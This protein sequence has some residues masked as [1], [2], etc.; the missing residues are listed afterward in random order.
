MRRG[1]STPVCPR[2]IIIEGLRLEQE[3]SEGDY[4]RE[5]FDRAQFALMAERLRALEGRFILSI[6]DLPE[7]RE[8]FAGFAMEE[9]ELLYTVSA[10]SHGGAPRKRAGLMQVQLRLCE[11][12]LYVPGLLNSGGSHDCSIRLAARALA[13]G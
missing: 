11:I 3:G 1:T 4:G 5:L 13:L 2:R 10:S 6:N 7:I 9:V 12:R 8:T